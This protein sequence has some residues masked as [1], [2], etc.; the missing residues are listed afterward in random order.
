[1][2]IGTHLLKILGQKQISEINFR[3]MHKISEISK[4]LSLQKFPTIW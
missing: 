3:K 4:N 2:A 1:M